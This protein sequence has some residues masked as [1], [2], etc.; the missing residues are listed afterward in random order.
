MTSDL[1]GDV[2]FKID[3]FCKETD[4]WV[5]I[6]YSDKKSG[7][8]HIKTKYEPVLVEKVKKGVAKKE[9]VKSIAKQP[10]AVLEAGTKKDLADTTNGGR[11]TLTIIEAVLTR[12]TEAYGKMDPFCQVKKGA[13]IMM[14]TNVLAEAGKTP[15]W[16]ETKKFEIADGSEF[17]EFIELVVMDADSYSNE[18]VGNISLHMSELCAKQPF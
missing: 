16:N 15:K 5:D 11:L 7:S 3:K 4:Q 2:T 13:S 17:L 12:N 18:T 8:I 10:V 1:I 6:F 14:K 9:E